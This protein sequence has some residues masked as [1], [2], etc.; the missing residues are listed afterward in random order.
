MTSELDRVAGAPADCGCCEGLAPATPAEVENRPGLS[1]VAYRAGTHPQFKQTMVARLSDAGRPALQRLNT[2]DDDDFSLALLDAWATVADVLT[3]YQERIANESYLRTATERRSVLE[4]ARL[5]G[6]ALRPGVA[7]GTYLAFTIEEAPGTTG[8][9]LSLGTTAQVVPAPPPPV[10]VA[11][12]TKVQSVPGENETAQI[13][14]TVE[15]VEARAEWNAMRPRLWQPQRLTG[16]DPFI[17]LKGTATNLKAGDALLV[18]GGSSNKQAVRTVL[19][20]QTDD[21]SNTTRVDFQPAPAG[22]PKYARPGLKVG[23]AAEL[24]GRKLDE[25]A[26]AHILSKRWAEADISAAAQMLDWS[27]AQLV[28]NLNEQAARRAPDA[29]VY[30]FRLRAG[31]FG[32]NAPKWDSLPGN[33]RFGE[34]IQGKVD[35][36]KGDL[37]VEPA[38]PSTW[39]G[40]TLDADAE[41]FASSGKGS[42]DRRYVYLDTTYPAAVAG[43]WALLRAASGP[44]VTEKAYAVADNVET[45]RSAFT[46][47]TKVTRLT[48]EADKEFGAAF[49]M[50]TTTVLA[51]SERLELADVPVADAVSGTEITLDRALLGLK[52]GKRL[53]LTGERADLEGVYASETLTLKEVTVEGGFTVLTFNETLAHTYLRETVTLNANVAASTHGETVSEVLGAGDAAQPFQSFR[54]RQPPLTY[55]PA[56]TPTGAETTLEVRVN[57]LLWQEVPTLYGRGPEERVYVTRADDDGGTTVQFGDGRTGARLPTGQDNVGAK[58]RRGTGAAGLVGANQLTQLL[59][60]P[61]GLKGVTNPLAAAEAEDPEPRDA[62]R[63]NAPLAILTLD[64]IVSLRDYEDF[65]AAFGGVAKSLATWTWTGER[66]GVFV[67]VAGPEGAT[68]AEGGTLHTNLLAAMRASGDPLVPLTVRSYRQSLFRIKAKVKVHPDYLP[69]KVLPEVE[70]TL[71]ARFSFDARGFGQP[72]TLG[73]VIAAFHTVAGVVA[74]DV[75]ALYR[76]GDK[77]PSCQKRLAAELPARG[78]GPKAAAAELLTLDP[79]PL[80]LEVLQ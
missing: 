8:Q 53:I 42:A 76:A 58:Y 74:V 4:L 72:V 75:D 25:K 26:V 20:V 6:Y 1:A 39:E 27:P 59:T 44:N 33:Q 38:Y 60:R 35:G 10:T 37:F 40:R 69:E 70:A 13:F 54:L 30:A 50:R 67:T 31:V 56:A 46:L 48:L 43:G 29:G 2:R 3:F 63:R 12:G 57:D 18:V 5:I 17:I 7:A 80:E 22:L 52:V 66:R 61:L 11:A 47:N 62:A 64:R 79:G 32:H 77:S 78:G 36:K 45:T 68:V 34:Y 51:Q 41:P 15:E 23:S 71:R 9:A 55:T 19:S 21:A 28:T 16:N 14:E 73:E 65:A 49:K 24:A